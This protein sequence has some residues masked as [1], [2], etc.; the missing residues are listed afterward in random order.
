MNFRHLLVI[1]VAILCPMWARA[2]ARPRISMDAF[3]NTGAR[4]AL[5]RLEHS[6]DEFKG[7]LDKALDHSVLNGTSLEDRLNQWANLLEDEVDTAKKEYNRAADSGKHA[8]GTAMERFADHWGNAMM[9]AT[10][11]NRAMI[12]RGFAPTP[13][14]QWT[15]IRTDLNMVAQALGNP[16]LPDMTVVIFR[17]VP[18]STLSSPNVKQV[19]ED[20][21]NSSHAF[22]DKI[23]HA[24]FV[25]AGPKERRVLQRWADD[26][27]SATNR[28]LDEYKDND[29]PEF[30][31][32]LEECLMLAAGLNRA[33][34]LTPMSTAPV[35]E[36][37]QLRSRLNTLA[38]QFGYPILPQTLR[39]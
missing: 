22:E 26:L 23:E 13:E 14:R 36:W 5:D 33:L 27:K 19:M 34:L 15:G 31:F 6:T 39:G 18:P 10:A 16:A 2:H 8:D 11:I 35:M 20:L 4:A 9:A 17:A 25:A 32:R 37:D 28:M 3:R 24:W 12:R 1:G 38:G 7:S 30:Q 29:A 21:R